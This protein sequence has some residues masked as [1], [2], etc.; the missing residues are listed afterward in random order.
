MQEELQRSRDQCRCL[1]EA[2][3][4]DAAI[5]KDKLMAQMTQLT[6]ANEQVNMLNMLFSILLTINI[7][8]CETLY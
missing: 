2:E 5:A 7:A 1:V 3:K 4:R 6:N 8:W